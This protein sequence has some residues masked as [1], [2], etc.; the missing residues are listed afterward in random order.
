MRKL[1]LLLCLALAAGLF[2]S[3]GKE[4]SAAPGETQNA[5]NVE[6]SRDS[7]NAT[8]NQLQQKGDGSG[9]NSVDVDALLAG[10]RIS[11]SHGSYSFCF[12]HPKVADGLHLTVSLKVF[13]EEDDGDKLL[14]SYDSD[15]SWLAR[16]QDYD[17]SERNVE[18]PVSVR[19]SLSEMYVMV[20]AKVVNEDGE[21]S[22]V[23]AV[24]DADGCMTEGF[25]EIFAWSG[26]Q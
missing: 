7:S 3:C 4:E 26:A 15:G 8:N 25:E 23:M 14:F 16:P 20:S 5:G 19:G 21:V 10:A 22:S 18:V 2:V 11:G 17:P 12:H 6:I 1:A 24:R 13:K 9:L